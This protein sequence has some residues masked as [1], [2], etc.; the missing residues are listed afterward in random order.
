MCIRRDPSRIGLH[1]MNIVTLPESRPSKEAIE[2]AQG[3][4][5]RCENG[6]VTEIVGIEVRP[7][8]SYL[9]SG[10]STVSAARRTGMLFA[11]AIDSVRKAEIE[12]RKK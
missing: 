8:G 10:T 5:A 11:A 1:P 2:Y 12:E 7:D 6:E 3:L 9:S 4:L